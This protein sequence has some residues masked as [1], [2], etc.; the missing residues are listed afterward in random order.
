[1]SSAVEDILSDSL[2]SNPAPPL[3]VGRSHRFR[4]ALRQ[5]LRVARCRLPVLILGESGSG[6]EGIARAIHAGG[7]R[8]AAPF[9]AVNCAALPEPLLEAELFGAERGA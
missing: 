1:M 5:A 6:K 7:D 4:E 8:R 2:R 9:L 3:L